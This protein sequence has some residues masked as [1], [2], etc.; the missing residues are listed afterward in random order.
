MLDQRRT[1]LDSIA[2]VVVGDVAESTDGSAVDVSAK[3]AVHPIAFRISNDRS[4]ELSDETNSI[5][6]PLLDVSAKRPVTEAEAAAE[7][8][9]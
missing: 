8:I 9:D 3:N 2:A 7:E 5:F 4:L 1:G 6:D